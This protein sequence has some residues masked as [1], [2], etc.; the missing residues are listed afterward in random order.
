MKQLKFEGQTTREEGATRSRS[1]RS[2][3]MNPLDYLAEFKA[4]QV[5]VLCEGWQRTTPRGC[6]L[7]GEP[8]FADC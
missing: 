6:E 8:E 7:N 3:Y 2:L 5:Q 4:A 1:S